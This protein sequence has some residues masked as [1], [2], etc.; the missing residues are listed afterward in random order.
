M[1]TPFPPRNRTNTEKT[2]RSFELLARYV[3]PHFQGQLAPIVA[4]RDWVETN[5]ATVFNHASG[6]FLKAFT[7]VG[8]ELPPAMVEAFK[9]G[10]A[11]QDNR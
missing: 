11:R 7:D 3:A 1:A 8:K 5:Q 9:A 4:N 6:A 2:W 10:A